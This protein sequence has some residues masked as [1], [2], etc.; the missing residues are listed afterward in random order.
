MLSFT[1][2]FMVIQSQSIPNVL[3]P[4]SDWVLHGETHIG[5][6]RA[7]ND[8]SQRVCTFFGPLNL[9]VNDQ[10]GNFRQQVRTFHETMVPLPNFDGGWPQS[11]R[12]NNRD[13]PIA[14]HGGSPYV[15]LR[16]GS[17]DLRGSMSWPSLPHTLTISPHTP[18]VSLTL[19][20]SRIDFPSRKEAGKIWLSEPKQDESEEDKVFCQVFR[21]WEDGVPI[22]LTTQIQVSV[23]GKVRN[24]EIP[25]PIPQAFHV[26]SIQSNLPY[27]LKSSQL[28]L[29]IRPGDWTVTL[30]GQTSEHLSHVQFPAQSPP[31]PEQE[32]VAFKTNPLIRQLELP[33]LSRLDPSQ[34]PI[35]DDWK[36]KP[37]FLL[38]P[39][40]HLAEKAPTNQSTAVNQSHLERNMWLDHDGK[41]FSFSDQ[42]SG[43]LT[44]GTFISMTTPYQ[45][46]SARENG[47]NLL[48]TMNSEQQPGLEIR[49][50]HFR[51]DLESRLS[52]R[53]ANFPATGLSIP[54]R[55]VSGQLFLPP[56]WDVLF[57]T[58]P[59]SFSRTWMNQWNL[60]DFFI[61]LLLCLS[62][63]RLWSKRVALLALACFV[64]CFQEPNLP[65]IIW[66]AIVLLTALCTYLP[67]GRLKSLVS[68][69]KRAT[70]LA[71]IFIIFSFTAFELRYALYPHLR[72]SYGIPRA[73]DTFNMTQ[74]TV[75]IL[76]SEPM[77]E[78][79]QTLSRQMPM[80]KKA[81]KM[82]K[83]S[84]GRAVQTGFGLPDWSDGTSLSFRTRSPIAPNQYVGL[85]LISPTMNRLITLLQVGILWLFLFTLMGLK[86]DRFKSLTKQ[87]L[88][89]VAFL[90]LFFIVVTPANAQIPD[91]DMLESLKQRLLE[92]PECLPSCANY[93]RADLQL[94]ENRLTIR[95]RV[96]CLADVVVPIPGQFNEWM[97]NEV[98]LGTRNVPL[99][100]QQDGSLWA[101]L[102]EGINELILSGPVPPQ[103]SFSVR[104]PL[105]LA[106]TTVSSRFWTFEA[107]RNNL[108][109]NSFIRFFRIEPEEGEELESSELPPFFELKRHLEFDQKWTV[110]STL[111]RV[112]DSRLSLLLEIPLLPQEAITTKGVETRDGKALIQLPGQVQSMSWRSQ[113]PI[114]DRVR[115]KA[116]EANWFTE[117]WSIWT[118]S[119]WQ[120]TFSGLDPVSHFDSEDDWNPV[121]KPWPEEELEL[122]IRQPEI[123]PGKTSTI[124]RT[125]LSL[126][127]GSQL[128]EHTLYLNLHTSTGGTKTWNFD[129][130]I[131]L[132]KLE[133]DDKPIPVPAPG[134]T[135]EVPLN[136]GKHRIFLDWEQPHALSWHY[137]TPQIDLGESSLNNSV[138]VTFPYNRWIIWVSGPSQGPVLLF[139]THILFFALISFLISKIPWVP[140]K[141][142]QILLLSLGL[143]QI[144][145]ATTFILYVWLILMAHRADSDR[146]LDFVLHN[147]R[148]LFIAFITI[149]ALILFLESIRHGLLSYPEMS[150]TGNGSYRDTLRWYLERP[151]I[152]T[153]HIFSVPL[154]IYRLLMLLWALW[155][156][157]FLTTQ[158]SWFWN[159]FSKGG[160]WRSPQKI[161]LSD[162]IS[163]PEPRRTKNEEE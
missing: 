67:S 25:L 72:P 133:I 7:F 153:V 94:D 131:T 141:F 125:D 102:R 24:W 106:N 122:S 88:S 83:Y 85:F 100:L 123:S 8:G 3:Q 90:V 118:S 44:R 121:W 137:R 132:N 20:G 42:L 18:F 134:A 48:I 32:I 163:Q 101:P 5:C 69:L 130:E 12:V 136:P 154:W 17:Y 112:G 92:P 104:F 66:I 22:Q 155:M 2:L 26:T 39:E 79:A 129:K 58:G 74:N 49:K 73:P 14:N 84:P 142:Y 15:V 55:S 135:L 87:G 52:E 114:Q 159:A 68:W 157:R 143:D 50:K 10:G 76:P 145:I 117:T 120:L 139:W 36:E 62:I 103:S 77:E 93:Q 46:G 99:H 4:W 23:S 110:H 11:F 54:V 150:I 82:R 59:F 144:H 149:V 64:L 127:P 111:T 128:S 61:L 6:L 124:N 115:L 13:Y 158:A 27:Q 19:N 160:L 95:L 16:E 53:K 35:P 126:V 70:L 57:A 148:Q 65:V 109:R 47:E 151:I 63:A 60:F 162:P 33:D 38:K 80:A 146:N 78:I 140:F 1:I 97:P 119:L 156:A 86:M 45:L 28:N 9:E 105:G 30:I 75:Q 71:L 138:S 107:P 81:P 89:T 98:I 37:C 21:L 113:L 31:W 29:Q 51:L 40:F 41:G 116:N 43:Q 152:P 34:L 161:I 96:D 147:L 56:G 91:A 108:S